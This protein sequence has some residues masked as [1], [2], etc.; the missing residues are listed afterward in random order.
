ML[1][2]E[3][4]TGQ[5]GGGGSF[6]GSSCGD[7]SQPSAVPA[8]F[9][10]SGLAPTSTILEVLGPCPEGGLNMLISMLL[11]GPFCSFLVVKPDPGD[12]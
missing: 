3:S 5:G 4:K 2:P 9:A 12:T 11:L 10:L 8:C 7:I 1:L 6:S